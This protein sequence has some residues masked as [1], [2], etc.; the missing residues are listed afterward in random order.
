[1]EQF[2]FLNTTTSADN[3]ATFAA[4]ASSSTTSSFNMASKLSFNKHL[5][6]SFADKVEAINTKVASDSTVD[7]EALSNEI[8]SLLKK[9]LSEQE[10]TDNK[11]QKNQQSIEQLL[12]KLNLND[13]DKAALVSELESKELENSLDDPIDDSIKESAENTTA[14][15]DDNVD[16]DNAAQLASK[17][18]KE[19]NLLI[20]EYSDQVIDDEA[21]ENTAQ[22]EVS[23][24]S[25]DEAAQLKALKKLINDVTPL[26]LRNELSDSLENI[27]ELLQEGKSSKI[28][29]SNEFTTDNEN[30]DNVKL[31]DVRA[32]VNAKLVEVNE[33]LAS[34]TLNKADRNQLTEQKT[35]LE[36]LVQVLMAS[37]LDNA[38][39]SQLVETTTGGQGSDKEL[40]QA[41]T[42]LNT[43]LQ[44]AKAAVRS[45]EFTNSSS[46][47]GDELA[48]VIQDKMMS[49]LNKLPP[50]DQALLKQEFEAVN[51]KPAQQKE[52]ITNSPD[53]FLTSIEDS[54]KALK[55]ESAPENEKNSTVGK[56]NTDTNAER[57]MSEK[58]RSEQGSKQSEEF[59]K[60]QPV[61]QELVLESKSNGELPPGDRKVESLISQL[62]SSFKATQQANNQAAD[63]AQI[64]AKTDQQAIKD[65]NAINQT[66]P[67]SIEASAPRILLHENVAAAQQ[68]KEHLT[69]MSRGGLGHAVLQLDP[70]ELGAMSVRIV[71]NNDQMN[72]SFHVQNPQAKELLEQAMGKLKES[73]EEQGIELQQSDVEQNS[74]GNNHSLDGDEQAGSDTSD[75]LDD[76]DGEPITLTLN[77][78]STNG[79]DYY[80]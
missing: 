30:I 18:M 26:S 72:V 36:E 42:L 20:S 70:E 39:L 27:I 76:T 62:E 29:D 22:S 9:D 5:E 8:I 46:L 12:S 38:K 35:E 52:T 61:K 51:S 66:A 63:I 13:R 21:H 3:M 56:G 25:N 41:L 33:L 80:A 28:D 40:K 69:M 37:P 7:I 77:K 1:L 44:E 16:T 34:E 54:H 4:S 58:N 60:E 11:K 15:N 31:D 43:H 64:N 67:K 49:L 6:Q 78:Q 10:A 74:D 47:T 2:N 48:L 50:K 53:K 68:L 23:A 32:K 59:T 17:N 79:I 45:N 19:L 55:Q 24:A 14:Y 65:A 71:M 57:V 75:E 73:L